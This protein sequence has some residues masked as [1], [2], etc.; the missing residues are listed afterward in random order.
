MIP[1]V[2]LIASD[3]SLSAGDICVAFI[4]DQGWFQYLQLIVVVMA[5]V[6]H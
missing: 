6:A 3:E 2:V 5:P 1:A 4:T